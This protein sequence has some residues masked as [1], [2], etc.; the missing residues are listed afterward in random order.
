MKS[1]SQILEFLNVSSNLANN[2][3]VESLFL[4]SRK[5]HNRSV[6][7]ALKGQLTDGNKYI[8]DVIAK[9]VSL[10]LTD[11][12][13][14]DNLSISNS[15][16]ELTS[17]RLSVSNTESLK[18]LH[19]ATQSAI[20]FNEIES[21]LIIYIEDLKDKLPDLAK[22]FYNYK[23]LQNII[24]VTGT[25]GK[26]S[27]SNY[28]AQ[29]LNLVEQKSLLLGTV[30]NGIYPDLEE[31]SHTT[32][33]VLSLYKTI[34]KFCGRSNVDS[35]FGSRMIDK[36]NNLVMEVSSH[37]LDQ[38]RI[39]GLEFDI[40]VFSNLSH[41]HLDY[42]T[43]ME[44]YFLAKA[45][46]FELSLL[47][48][49]VINIDDE[50]GKKLVGLSVAPVVTVSLKSKQADI[51]VQ[52]IEI[53]NIFTNFN[54]YIKGEFAGRFKTCLIGEFNLMNLAL[55]IGALI[56]G[57]DRNLL[58]K[59]IKRIL[60]VKGRM[61]LIQLSNDV[62][63]VIDYAHTP[64]ALEKALQT[65]RKYSKTNL[66]C[67]FGCGGNR[68]KTKRSKMA[69]I[70]E[71]YA[72]KVVITEDNNRFENIE[73]IFS[74]IKKGFIHP[75]NHIFINSRVEAIS[76]CIKSSYTHD[77]I[78]LAGKGHECYID[79]NGVKECFDEREIISKL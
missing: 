60:P 20:S 35:Q 33:D 53:E 29:F 39:Q 67:V 28:I 36:I 1:I 75:N 31:S 79:K 77:V 22:W 49:S 7:I 5:C 9:G 51:Y 69:A 72:D 24:G 13:G 48:K 74:D 57:V 42:H 27:I 63:V 38:K 45:K 14:L 25:N 76:Y 43:T 47:K 62:K 12:P 17:S 30:G 58:F 56:D 37:S 23:K 68:D 11:N 10:I 71:K 34:S 40:A 19:L 70:A 41:D 8:Y 52:F 32:L 59:N 73:D 44:N 50:Y 65:L 46:L 3:K 54:L 21:P 55:S 16:S 4:D 6:F 78:L 64:D 15:Q 61:E 66:W 26:T 2:I 18:Q